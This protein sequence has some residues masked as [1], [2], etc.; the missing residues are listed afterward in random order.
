[1]DDEKS[2]YLNTGVYSIASLEPT[3]I[4]I[5]GQV[6]ISLKDGSIEFKPGYSPSEAAR[7]FWEAISQDYRDMLRWKEEHKGD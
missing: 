1:M 7:L 5:T 4:V 2:P 3:S 6:E